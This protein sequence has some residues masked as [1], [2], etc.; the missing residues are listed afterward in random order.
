MQTTE[1]THAYELRSQPLQNLS[2]RMIADLFTLV[3]S[4]LQVARLEID[5]KARVAFAA[6][7]ALTFATAFAVLAMLALGASI[8]AGLSM[9][10]PVWLSALIVAVVAALIGAGL[11]ADARSTVAKAGGLLPNQTLETLWLEANPARTP[12]ETEQ[13]AANARQD[14]NKTLSA[15]EQRSSRSSPIRDAILSGM[16]VTLGVV[17]QARNTRR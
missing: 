17:M 4:E 9:L 15:V 5:E 14:F 13:R 11:A 2:E 1:G 7:R 16:G 8:V 10:I 6:G 3:R 12:D